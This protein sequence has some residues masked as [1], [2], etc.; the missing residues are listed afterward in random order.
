LAERRAPAGGGAGSAGGGRGGHLDARKLFAHGW[1]AIRDVGER[2]RRR[3][4]RFGLPGREGGR[5][6]RHDALRQRLLLR[7]LENVDLGLVHRAGG[8]CSEPSG[9]TGESREIKVALSAVGSPGKGVVYLAKFEA[10]AAIACAP[11][12]CVRGSYS[13][14]HMMQSACRRRMILKSWHDARAEGRVD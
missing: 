3:R 8:A 2:L 14:V 12:V 9:A 1:V 13:R 10:M 6:Q 7:G 4:L 11:L 5:E